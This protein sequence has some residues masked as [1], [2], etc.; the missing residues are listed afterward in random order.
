M[1]HKTKILIVDDHQ[2]VIQG[3]LCSL[4]EVGDFEVVT[5]TDCDAA[6]MLIKACEKKAHFQI[7]FTDLS[8]D[9]TTQETNL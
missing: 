7:L 5:T 4:K 6:F 1:V 9:N 2:L 3:L 8:F